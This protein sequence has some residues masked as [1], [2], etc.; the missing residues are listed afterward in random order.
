VQSAVRQGTY[1]GL[2]TGT[3]AFNSVGDRREAN[4]YVMKLNGTKATLSTT[5]KVKAPAR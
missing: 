1:S 4:L 5:V 3:V 2:L